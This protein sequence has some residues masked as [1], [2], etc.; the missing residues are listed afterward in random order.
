ME[1]ITRLTLK[2]LDA[3]DGIEKICFPNDATKREYWIELLEDERTI[4][5]AI[6]EDNIVKSYIA[7]YNWKGENDYIKIMS[8]GT[9][10]A[11]R[12]KGYAHMIMQHTIDEMLKDDMRIFKAETR[13]SNVKMQKVFEDF[14]YKM[15]GKVAECYDN[16]KEGAYKY[17]LEL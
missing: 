15:I 17:S 14:G 2:D 13:E 10:P 7:I 12:N 8:I 1:N 4:V 11:Y 3:I 5:F 16:P 9:H 6:K